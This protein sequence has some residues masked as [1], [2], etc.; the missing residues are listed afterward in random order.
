MSSLV[1]GI[2][3]GLGLVSIPL[4]HVDL[5]KQKHPKLEV[6]MKLIDEFENRCRM[7]KSK[8]QRMLVKL[9]GGTAE[10]GIDTG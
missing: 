1:D 6:V 7:V 2:Q 10:L 8:R 4:Q 3:M 9:R 5:S